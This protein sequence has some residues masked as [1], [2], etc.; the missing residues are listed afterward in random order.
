MEIL[1]DIYFVRS[2]YLEVEKKDEAMLVLEEGSLEM[3]KAMYE[4]DSRIDDLLQD[5]AEYKGKMQTLELDLSEQTSDLAYVKA[6]LEASVKECSQRNKEN[7]TLTTQLQEAKEKSSEV[8]AKLSQLEIAGREHTSLLFE[9]T[10]AERAIVVTMN[11]FISANNAAEAKKSN[12][13]KY[14]GKVPTDLFE[15]LLASPPPPTSLIYASPTGS[16]VPLE[17]RPDG[18]RLNFDVETVPYTLGGMHFTGLQASVNALQDF[19]SH[20]RAR[21]SGLEA[22]LGAAVSR[23]NDIE[24]EYKSLQ[25]KF[26]ERSYEVAQLSSQVNISQEE[27][28]Q[29]TAEQLHLTNKFESLQKINGSYSYQLRFV[30]REIQNIL[31]SE[32]TSRGQAVVEMYTGESAPL[33]LHSSS[34]SKLAIR[35]EDVD[36]ICLVEDGESVLLTE[37]KKSMTGFSSC[38]DS[39]S[40]DLDARDRDMKQLKN[41]VQQKASGWEKEKATL[42]S[43]LALAAE[44]S[45]E[46]KLVNNECRS[47]LQKVSEELNVVRYDS[48]RDA[49][50]IKGLEVSLRNKSSEIL[51][52][53]EELELVEKQHNDATEELRRERQSNS[54]TMDILEKS[55]YDVQSLRQKITSQNLLLEE[56][57]YEIDRLLSSNQ[58]ANEVRC[59]L[60]SELEQTRHEL[61]QISSQKLK[62]SQTAESKASY[63]AERLLAALAATVDHMACSSQGNVSVDQSIDLSQHST[64]STTYGSGGNGESLVVRVDQA[65]KKLSEMRAWAREEK[66][67]NRK[68][69]SSVND[70]QRELD[71]LKIASNERIKS[72]TT[73]LSEIRSHQKVEQDTSALISEKES[74]VSR[75]ETEITALQKELQIYRSSRDV[76]METRVT[77]SSEILSKDSAISRLSRDKQV[78]TAENENLRSKLE[79]AEKA[80]N[81]VTTERNNLLERSSSTNSTTSNLQETVERLE[82]SAERYKEEI[83]AL[84][85]RLI[86]AASGSGPS[87]EVMRRN[88]EDLEKT[89]QST[90]ESY[91]SYRITAEERYSRSTAEL[92]DCRRQI[93]QLEGQLS[94]HVKE[95]SSTSSTVAALRHELHKAQTKYDMET[96]EWNSSKAKFLTLRSSEDEWR[97]QL[98]AA[99]SM[100]ENMEERYCFCSWFNFL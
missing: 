87:S 8:A 79:A 29:L 100:L 38:L 27:L 7:A 47:L 42:Q 2:L 25:S 66:R 67:A 43:R 65:V 92:E 32:S 45:E 88:C 85:K 94:I 37:I 16:N 28:E 19:I 91:D 26:T 56:K 50:T 86:A 93:A 14:S 1:F 30:K 36:M 84:Q 39:L 96:S 33:L 60:E 76:D 24:A 99:A 97:L 22:A 98:D 59:T 57:S 35:D 75:L 89:L 71:S 95:N 4:A 40:R 52:L 70:L 18:S 48:E 72:L 80:L 5:V 3:K 82:Q 58:S 73:D 74:K 83:E 81:S 68:L 61:E 41:D 10:A 49:D 53:R 13:Q 69:S 77:L 21:C 78:Y 62:F 15:D 54:D 12:E 11:S 51:Q 31:Y 64:T 23:S 63:E 90:K 44:A 9:L 6:E 20:Y 55:Q 46:E 17:E 34:H